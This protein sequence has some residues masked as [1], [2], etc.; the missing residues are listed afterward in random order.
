MDSVPL[1]F[2]IFNDPSIFG[3]FLSGLSQDC[4][5]ILLGECNTAEK[6]QHPVLKKRCFRN[7]GLS[8]VLDRLII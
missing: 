1:I 3:Q 6:V 7:D 4:G 5:D 2:Q 8:D